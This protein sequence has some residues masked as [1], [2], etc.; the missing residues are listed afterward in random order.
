[1]PR[2]E[3]YTRNRLRGQPSIVS[4]TVHT[5]R[6]AIRPQFSPRTSESDQND[7]GDLEGRSLYP[8]PCN[9]GSEAGVVFLSKTLGHSLPAAAAGL[10]GGGAT[11]QS[12]TA[13][14]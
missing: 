7:G 5:M 6:H 11:S 12:S 8:Q 3:A 1:M 14:N 4:I 9:N 10:R 2:S 13:A